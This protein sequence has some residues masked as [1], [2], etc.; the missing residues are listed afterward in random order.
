MNVGTEWNMGK[1]VHF[2]L[3]HVGIYDT[4]SLT[5]GS[6]DNQL[7][8]LTEN[9]LALCVCVK[10]VNTYMTMI[11]DFRY[12]LIFIFHIFNI[13]FLQNKWNSGLTCYDEL[14]ARNEL[15]KVHEKLKIEKRVSLRACSI[16]CIK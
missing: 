3:V 2:N 1:G 16:T 14:Y 6:W 10:L 12:F 9:L 11:C 13:F 7:S 8:S 15:K 5:M 4:D